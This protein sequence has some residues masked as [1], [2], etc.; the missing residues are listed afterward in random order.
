MPFDPTSLVTPT[1]AVDQQLAD[2]EHRRAGEEANRDT[3]VTRRRLERL[4]NELV[5]DRADQDARAERHDQTE[6]A[7]TDRESAGDGAT[8]HER[9]A[10]DEPPHERLA[11]QVA[12]TSRPALVGTRRDRR[13]LPGRTSRPRVQTVDGL[14]R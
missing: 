1:Q 13:A 5:G 3:T 12:V 4:V 9:Q 2:E 11:H 14:L 10:G 8:D 7:A 6:H